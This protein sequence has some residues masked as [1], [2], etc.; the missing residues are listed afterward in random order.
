[1]VI[2]S[3]LAVSTISGEK[4]TY[5][6]S[7]SIRNTQS[8]AF[9][10]MLLAVSFGNRNA[11]FRYAVPSSVRNST[12]EIKLEAFVVF[13]LF[14]QYMVPILL[15]LLSK[16]GHNDSCIF[17]SVAKSCN[18]SGYGVENN[19]DGCITGTVQG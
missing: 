8:L 7:T 6:C 1:M 2:S 12:V 10:R 15:L 3:R 4:I 9:V 16:F 19:F 11:G 14:G 13:P 17:H 18:N 5:V